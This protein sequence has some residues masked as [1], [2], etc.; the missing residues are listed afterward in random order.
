M[1]YIFSFVEFYAALL[2]YLVIYYFIIILN[3][4]LIWIPHN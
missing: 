3:M 2:I 1:K 4:D